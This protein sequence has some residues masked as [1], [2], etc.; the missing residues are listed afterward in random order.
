LNAV[1]ARA[2]PINVT[3]AFERMGVAEE[4]LAKHKL[5]AHPKAFMHVCPPSTMTDKGLEVY[6]AHVI[7]LCA[8][9]INQQPV[10]P[11]TDAEILCVIL[12]AATRAPLRSHIVQA[13]ERL[14]R[15]RI[16]THVDQLGEPP[17]ERFPQEVTEF[18]E[19][20]RK[21]IPTTRQS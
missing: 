16:A 17:P 3:R 9:I 13:A 5:Q 11:A 20:T 12:D 15:A 6:R 1:I 7:E 10:E 2:L 19:T 8:R 21:Q 18:I 14:F 4:E